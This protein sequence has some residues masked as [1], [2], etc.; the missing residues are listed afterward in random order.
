MDWQIRSAAAM[1]EKY[2]QVSPDETDAVLTLLSTAQE[3]KK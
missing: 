2:A 3:G 1:I